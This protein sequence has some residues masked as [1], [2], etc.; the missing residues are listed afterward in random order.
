VNPA[1]QVV[2][3]TREP[4]ETVLLARARDG[5]ET[6]VDALLRRYLNDVYAVTFRVL[7]DRELAQDAAQDALVGALNGLHR[8]RGAASFRT[9]LIRIAI[10]AARSAGRRKTRRREVSLEVVAGNADSGT[11]AAT[12]TARNREAARA[13]LMLE[14]LPEKQRLAV[15]L[16]I[17]R[18][19]SYKEIGAALDCTEGAARVNY[20][21]GVKRLRELMT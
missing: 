15:S 8:F 7:G 13:A 2:E 20:H 10:N 9:W 3:P 4:D 16:R 14:R 12:V 17:N 1:V 18:G 11:D 6:A 21:L 5:D 19:L